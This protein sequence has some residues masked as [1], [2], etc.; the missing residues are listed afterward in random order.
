VCL[1]LCAAPALGQDLYWQDGMVYYVLPLALDTA[2]LALLLRA[3]STGSQTAL[4]GILAFA[5]AGCHE[6]AIILQASLCVLVPLAL[7]TWRRHVAALTAMAMATALGAVLDLA[8]PG[9]A[10]RASYYP[11]HAALISALGHAL[12]QA[13]QFTAQ[14]TPILLTAGM[15]GALFLPRLPRLAR[16]R[17]VLMLLLSW[18]TAAVCLVPSWYAEHQAA[19]DRNLLFPVAILIGAALWAGRQI[20]PGRCFRPSLRLAVSGLIALVCLLYAAPQLRTWQ[21]QAPAYAARLHMLQI[22]PH[23]FAGPF[24]P[25]ATPGGLDGIVP[26]GWVAVCARHA[27]G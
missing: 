23:P 24:A 27:V 9:N 11:A 25:I 3:A 14:L 18:G 17:L 8:A 1:V 2:L 26:D 7:P 20:S 10:V 15:A 5:G 13:A 4:V 6:S 12:G 16:W 19:P 21:A 22:Q